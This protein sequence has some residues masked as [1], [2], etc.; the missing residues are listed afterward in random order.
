MADPSYTVITGQLVKLNAVDYSDQGMD[1]SIEVKVDTADLTNFGS[2]GWKFPV[3]TLKSGDF[4]ASIIKTPAIALAL[5]GQLGARVP[6]VIRTDRDSAISVD[7]LEVRGFAV[8]TGFKPV[9]GKP[10]DPE[11]HELAW[12]SSGEV[13][14]HSAP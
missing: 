6:F 10:G 9:G 3:G 13:T 11:M 14:L 4:K 5:W 8:N 1:A 7:N 12:P 2:A